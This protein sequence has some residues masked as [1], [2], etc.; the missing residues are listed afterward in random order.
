MIIR[1]SKGELPL[2]NDSSLDQDVPVAGEAMLH[3]NQGN[4]TGEHKTNPG[5]S[6]TDRRFTPSPNVSPDRKVTGHTSIHS[7]SNFI[8]NGGSI[9]NGGIKN[10]RHKYRE[11][12]KQNGRTP[13]VR[14]SES[15]VQDVSTV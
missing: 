8:L 13:A 11:Q 5:I 6:I 7:M 1:Y 10:T 4:K 3:T 14:K 12:P 2:R 15:H 9:M